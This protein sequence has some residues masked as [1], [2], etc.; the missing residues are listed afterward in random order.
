[1]SLKIRLIVI[2]FINIC[3]IFNIKAQVQPSLLTINGRFLMDDC[4]DT[5]IL[6]G[7]NHGNIWTTNWGIDELPEIEKSGA[8]C[9]R[10][11]LEKTWFNWNTNTL[12]NIN[13]T[14]IEQII[15]SCL[16]FKMIPIIELH[17]YTSVS[18]NALVTLP[19]AVS[20]WISPSILNLIKK[21]QNYL[22]LNIANEP[23]H[24]D[25]SD[26]EYY[27]ANSQAINLL[28]NAGIDAPIM[29]DAKTW[30][31]EEIFFYNYG[32]NLIQNDPLHK[33]LFSVHAYW[34]NV[35]FSNQQLSSKFNAMSL[36]NLPFV[37]GEFSFFNA[38]TNTAINYSKLLDLMHQYSI[39]GLA[40]WWGFKNQSSNN[41]LSF[42][43][44][45][46]FS[47]LSNEGLEITVNNIYSIKNTSKRIYKLVNGDCFLGLKNINN[48]EYNIW[49]N[50]TN[51]DFIINSSKII[52][53]LTI[54]TQLGEKLHKKSICNSTAIINDLDLENGGYI[55]K[56]QFS[57]NTFGYSKLIVEK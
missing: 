57:D 48:C 34:D 41:V 14:N 22:I 42:T 13:A 15:S 23:E 32:Q 40:W 7:F 30:G 5:I 6:K 11:C 53:E 39:G 16:S 35:S 56:I 8:N 9:V 25:L 17:D 55:V 21:Y 31:T 37:L 45:G 28:R 44:N 52:N 18:S 26:F 1:M 20:F 54:L 38:S 33:L 36:S 29:I 50:P 51:H 10:I 19:D 46:L 2:F 4:G 3:F 12:E 43:T 24:G 47:G 49:P 27:N